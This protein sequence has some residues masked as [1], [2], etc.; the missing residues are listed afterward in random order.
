M[1][2]DQKIQIPVEQNA[3]ETTSP[4]KITKVEEEQ[5]K[6]LNYIETLSADNLLFYTVIVFVIVS[7]FSQ[8]TIGLNVVLGLIV[9]VITCIF[10]VYKQNTL[11]EG[12]NLHSMLK[13]NSLIPVPEFFYCDVN[14]IEVMYNLLDYHDYSP[15][16]YSAT[17]QHIDN[18]LG[19]TLDVETGI[20]NCAEVIS[21]MRKERDSALKSLQLIQ[22]SLPY[23][24]ELT[25]KLIK[26]INVIELYLNRH[27]QEAME[28]CKGVM[29][30]YEGV[31]VPGKNANPSKRYY[32]E[33][34]TNLPKLNKK[35]PCG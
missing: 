13:L 35:T 6:L 24:Q 8:F 11:Q 7:V 5:F 22:P 33:S 10:L 2:F 16:N 17:I 3:N 32:Q 20:V 23:S 30:I 25:D 34:F 29:F 27:I 1:S 12:N 14:L 21:V 4:V 9:S 26:G 28:K 15:S 31:D 19:L 18:I